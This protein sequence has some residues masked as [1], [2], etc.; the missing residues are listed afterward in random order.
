MPLAS[1]P[2]VTSSVLS[3]RTV[4]NRGCSRVQRAAA[5]AISGP[6]L[7]CLERNQ[8]A[9]CSGLTLIN[10]PPRFPVRF[11]RSRPV[12]IGLAPITVKPERRQPVSGARTSQRPPG[13]TLSGAAGERRV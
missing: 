7:G 2:A 9:G 12:S 1:L 11:T 5:V 4:C 3:R 6:V 13:A 10:G 8:R